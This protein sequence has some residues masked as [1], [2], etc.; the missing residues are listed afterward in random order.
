[1]GF[2]PPN[3][4]APANDVAAPA[5]AKP[6]MPPSSPSPFVDPASD[7][8][9]SSAAV[10]RKRSPNEIDFICC[11]LDSPPLQQRDPLRAQ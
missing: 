6:A 8:H 1:M 11:S 7:E 3:D 2:T 10:T 9:P 5:P 4:G